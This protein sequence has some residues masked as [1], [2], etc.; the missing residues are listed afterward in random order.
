LI[1]VG[2]DDGNVQMTP[3]GGFQWIN[4]ATPA[5]DKWVSRVVASKWD[6]KT[7]YVSQ[8]GYREDDFS[9]YLW[10]STDYGKTWKSIVGNLPKETI[11]VVREDPNRNDVLYVGTDMGVYISF[12]GGST[13]DMIKGN[14]PNTP[15]HDLV[16]QPSAND[17]V[18]ATHARS[19]WIIPLK[20]ILSITP[21]LRKT[22]LKLESLDNESDAASWGYDRKERWDTSDPRSPKMTAEFWTKEPGKASLRI[23]DKAGKVI[24]EKLFDATRGFNTTVMELQ[25]TAPKRTSQQKQKVSNGT[26]ALNDP[27]AA[28]RATYVPIGEYKLVLTV[29]THSVDQA[30]KVTK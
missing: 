17:L 30:W 20:K 10:K 16:V 25:L 22:D 2:C 14:L 19:V 28:N 1:Y 29:G 11:N 27:Y 18:V 23:V 21:E 6:E 4:I 12:D 5:P 15:V 13:W 24:K 3:D 9:P 7:V 8:S 26:D